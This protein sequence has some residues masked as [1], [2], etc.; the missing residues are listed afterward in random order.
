MGDVN[1]ER[2]PLLIRKSPLKTPPGPKSSLSSARAGTRGADE[3][4]SSP[5]SHA[6]PST[7]RKNNLFGIGPKGGSEGKD[8]LSPSPVT[9]HR[10]FRATAALGAPIAGALALVIVAFLGSAAYRDRVDK[11]LV[12]QE[13]VLE[14]VKQRTFKMLE[15]NPVMCESCA[16]VLPSRAYAGRGFGPHI[17]AADC[18]VRFNNY[19]Y[20]AMPR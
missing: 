1:A 16:V 19:D 13:A 5:L 4:I 8:A 12:H 15:E 20:F 6:T 7:P 14:L 3:A 17:D 10:P 2:T 9:P 11:D 18:V